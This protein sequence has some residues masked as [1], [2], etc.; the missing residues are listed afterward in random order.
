[1]PAGMPDVFYL[2]IQDFFKYASKGLLYRW[3]IISRR[4]S[5]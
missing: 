4:Q 1:M 3:M 5:L 2:H